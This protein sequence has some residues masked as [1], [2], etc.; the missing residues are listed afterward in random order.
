MSKKRESLI[1]PEDRIVTEA[2]KYEV[3]CGICCDILE[4]P[5][6][7][8]SGHV[9]CG[10]CIT[11]CIIK[12]MP[13]PT[14]RRTLTEETVARNLFLEEYCKEIPIHCQYH[15]FYPDDSGEIKPDEEN[16]CPDKIPYSKLESH[17]KNCRYSWIRCPF[18]YK[19]AEHKVRKLHWKDHKIICEFRPSIC[20]YCDASYPF[21]DLNVR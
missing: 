12:G 3:L 11:T 4:H 21:C 14:C 9:Y 8:L 20:K 19:T 18:T 13:C 5:R 7:C 17:E 10:N 16:G 1:A 6:Q 15:Y 2:L